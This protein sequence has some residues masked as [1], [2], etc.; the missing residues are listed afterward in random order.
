MNTVEIKV[1]VPVDVHKVAKSAAALAGLP[2][3][4]FV[5]SLIVKE[6]GGPAKAGK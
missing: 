2:L 4:A 6:V 1:N 3:N 5:L